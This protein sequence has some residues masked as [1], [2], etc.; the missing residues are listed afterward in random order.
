MTGFEP[1]ASGVESDRSVNWVSTTAQSLE[2]N[3]FGATFT[4][5]IFDFLELFQFVLLLLCTFCP[6]FFE[7]QLNCPPFNAKNWPEEIHVSH[8]VITIFLLKGLLESSNHLWAGKSANVIFKVLE[9]EQHGSHTS[10][11]WRNCLRWVSWLSG[12]WFTLLGKLI[13]Q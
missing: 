5:E 4:W 10:L 2:V 7:N 6:S 9:K 12:V 11:A 13:N 8:F 3:P 1:R